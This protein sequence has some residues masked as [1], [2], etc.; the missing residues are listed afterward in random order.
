MNECYHVESGFPVSKGGDR[1]SYENAGGEGEVSVDDS[2]GLLVSGGG[3]SGVK[4]GPVQ[5]EED[6][7]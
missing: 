5:P 4:T 1:E 6:G 3:D 7:S 2:S